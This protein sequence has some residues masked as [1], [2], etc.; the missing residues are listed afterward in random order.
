MDL[1][2]V[3]QQLSY[4]FTDEQWLIFAL[5]HPSLK[6]HKKAPLQYER[7]EYLG[8]AV[9]ELVVSRELMG[10]FTKADEG[11]LTKLRSSIVSRKHLGD[12]CLDLKWDQ[13]IAMDA[14]VEAQGGRAIHSIL[15]N[16]FES[17]IGAVMMDSNYNA[18]SKV[19]LMLLAD[20]LKNVANICAETNPKGALLE[21]LQSIVAIHPIYRV[22]DISQA[23]RPYY[24][25]TVSWQGRDL[26]VGE[27]ES[28]RS[29]EKQAAQ[30]A[31]D[32]RAWER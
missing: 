17:V 10:L 25:A 11:Q 20:S 5:T 16:T 15:A 23:G 32:A 6:K 21:L 3:E 27:G 1:R 19:S 13:Q 18:A 2:A 30:L 8:D 7:L 29:A 26:A 9:L 24:R 28:K 4:T 12:L 14:H 22:D 31:L